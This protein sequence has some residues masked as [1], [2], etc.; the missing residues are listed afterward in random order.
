MALLKL[1]VHSLTFNG[2]SNLVTAP[3]DNSNI[4]QIFKFEDAGDGKFYLKNMNAD[5]YLNKISVGT[6]RS[7][8]VTEADACKLQIFPNSTSAAHILGS[9]YI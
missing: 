2:S 8:I 9:S 6:Y 3:T 4:N 5:G 7:A 1:F